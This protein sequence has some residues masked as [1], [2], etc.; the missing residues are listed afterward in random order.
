LLGFGFYFTRGGVRIRADPKALKRFKD[1]IRELTSR[2]RSIAM[3]VRI[4]ALNRYVTGWM[5]YCV[6]RGHARLDR[7]AVGSMV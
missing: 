1:R 5:G 2:R 7:R 6:S 4:A 3:D